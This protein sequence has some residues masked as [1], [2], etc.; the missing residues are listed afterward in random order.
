[1]FKNFIELTIT[2]LLVGKSGNKKAVYINSNPDF[3]ELT[4][5]QQISEIVWA[6]KYVGL[7]DVAEVLSGRFEVEE[8]TG[9]IKFM[10]EGAENHYSR[11]RGSK[12][13][14]FA[15]LLAN[16]VGLNKANDYI[17]DNF[18]NLFEELF[19]KKDIKTLI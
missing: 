10:L 11:M 5:N 14:L 1:M 15:K 12:Q 18:E 9:V 7:V 16:R 17:M 6:A 13:L 3:Q 2:M 19:D 8:P 4:L